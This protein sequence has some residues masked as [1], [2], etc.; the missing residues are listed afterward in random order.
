MLARGVMVVLGRC[1]CSVR[2]ENAYG[3]RILVIIIVVVSIMIV[4]M[5]VVMVIMIVVMVIMVGNVR[6]VMAVIVFV[7]EKVR[8]RKDHKAQTSDSQLHTGRIAA[9]GCNWV[10][11]PCHS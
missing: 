8:S 1:V 7:I 11:C 6:Q 2:V 10:A 9:H 3:R 5:I 4:I